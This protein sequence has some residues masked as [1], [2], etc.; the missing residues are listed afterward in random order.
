MRYDL[1][2]KTVCLIENQKCRGP[3]PSE[4]KRSLVRVGEEKLSQSGATTPTGGV[5]RHL[6]SFDILF[7]LFIFLKKTAFS[8]CSGASLCWCWLFVCLFVCHPA[9]NG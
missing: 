1:L 7:A 2:V 8:H 4:E 5:T 6:F 9:E 3:Y